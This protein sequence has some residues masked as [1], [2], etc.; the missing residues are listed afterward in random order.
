M[1]VQETFILHWL[2]WSGQPSTKYFFLTLLYFTFL[3][4]IDQ[5]PGRAVVQGRPECVYPDLTYQALANRK[6]IS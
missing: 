4:L 3:V 5:Q 6:R 2:L 1:P